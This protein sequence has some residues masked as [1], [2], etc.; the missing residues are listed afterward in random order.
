MIV[1]A[2]TLGTPSQPYI[3]NIDPNPK[4]RWAYFDIVHYHLSDLLWQ[5]C[6]H[7]LLWRKACNNPSYVQCTIHVCSLKHLYMLLAETAAITAP[8]T[9]HLA[10]WCTS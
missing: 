8:E 2:E 7:C 5:A 4:Y 6:P 9:L 10:G 3:P 1:A